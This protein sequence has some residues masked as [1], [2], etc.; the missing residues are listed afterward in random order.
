[1]DDASEPSNEGSGGSRQRQRVYP[2]AVLAQLAHRDRLL[3]KDVVPGE[4]RDAVANFLAQVLSCRDGIGRERFPQG[5]LAEFE[6]HFL[7]TTRARALPGSRSPFAFVSA[8]NFEL[9]YG[10]NLACQHCLQEGVRPTGEA[11]WLDVGLV[12]QALEDAV[13]LGFTTT[14][15]NF[16]GGEVYLPGSPVLDL[17]TRAARLGARVRCNTNGWWGKRRD[18]VVGTTSF[19]WSAELVERLRAIGLC[20]LAMSLDER[21]TQYP[22]LLDR[23]L[24]VAARCEQVGL[25]YEFVSTDATPEQVGSAL[26][27]LRQR[28][29]HDPKHLV[30]ARRKRPR[31]SGLVDATDIGGAAGPPERVLEPTSLTV[32]SAGTPCKN[33]GFYRP[34]YLHVNPDGGVRSCLL[35]PGSSPLGYLAQERLPEI[36]NRADENPIVR[37]FADG[38]TESFVRDNIT[39][40]RHLYRSVDHPCA[41]SPLIARVAEVLALEAARA[42][43]ELCM[44]DRE[45]VHVKIAQE[46]NLSSAASDGLLP[47]GTRRG[48]RTWSG[49]SSSSNS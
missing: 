18:F 5:W 3:V 45:A 44:E 27:A 33:R 20:T 8:I 23:V 22:N 1:M 36:L 24:A 19:R 32:L 2:S 15:V 48:K 38:L 9:T 25:Q 40:W 16:T 47:L 30:D 10:C 17:I 39:P 7:V 34:A 11:S 12:A 46:W 21:Y 49:T 31:V 28:I 35:A 4:R 14:G 37:L 41:A 6:R 43:R 29:G 13:W 42:G 26:A